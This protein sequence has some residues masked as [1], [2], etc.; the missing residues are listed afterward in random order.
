MRKFRIRIEFTLK[1][2]ILGLIKYLKPNLE[3][4]KIEGGLGSQLLGSLDY[5]IKVARFGDANVFAD[6]S[7]FQGGIKSKNPNV[8]FWNWELS[9][10]GLGMEDFTSHFPI[11]KFILHRYS[12]NS[13]SADS[14]YWKLAREIGLLKFP[15]NMP[16]ISK[17]LENFGI[18]KEYGVVHIRRGD[19]LTA[20]SK[21]M[22]EEEYSQL[23]TQI[24]NILPPCLVMI[25][26]SDISVDSRI[27]FESTTGVPLFFLD[28]PDLDPVLLHDLMRN[29]KLLVTSNS[30]FSFS[31]GILANP[32]T[33]V[34]SPMYFYSS[35][36]SELENFFR[37]A[38]NFTLRYA[39]H[40]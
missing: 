29:S 25:S 1:K 30:T 32:D 10:Y 36:L 7:Y 39:A 5:F 21:I 26:D 37:S 34:F 35:G 4:I 3:V 28:D 24:Q 31:A 23:L 33:I 6:V 22:S 27:L 38:G 13:K 16:A 19:Y 40:G 2:R 17:F 14:E 12:T 8:T 15:I 20:A 11:S 18:P 9:S